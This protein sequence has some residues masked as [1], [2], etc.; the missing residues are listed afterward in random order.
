GALL[1]REGVDDKQKQRGENPKQKRDENKVGLVKRISPAEA[2]PL[3]VL[4]IGALG[5]LGGFGGLGLT[6]LGLGLGGVA[7]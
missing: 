4:P 6:G 5:G 1:K 3:A 7:I 2:I